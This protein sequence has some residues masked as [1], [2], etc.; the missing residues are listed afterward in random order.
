MAQAYPNAK[1]IGLDA[2]PAED[3]RMKGYS[4]A[5]IGAPNIVY[6][7]GDLTAQ[8]T[9]PDNYIDVLYQRDT[10]S[11]IPHER[12]PFLFQE[13]MRVIKPGGHVELVEYGKNCFFLKLILLFNKNYCYNR[14]QHSR[15]WTCSCISK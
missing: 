6:K 4:N 13:L 5:T 1:V 11:I 10:T 15:S 9:L 3:K 7:Y 8:L 2:F 14:L 12:W